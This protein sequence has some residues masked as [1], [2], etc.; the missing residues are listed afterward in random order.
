MFSSKY[1]RGL[2]AVCLILTLA[3]AAS[4]APPAERFLAAMQTLSD[5][6]A[7]GRAAT[8][9][10]AANFTARE[11]QAVDQTGGGFSTAE[12]SAGNVRWGE[13]GNRWDYEELS[14]DP[15]DPDVL[16]GEA[17]DV[18]RELAESRR[19]VPWRSALTRSRRI[20]FR[21]RPL[22]GVVRPAE[23]ADDGPLDVRPSDCWYA[24]VVGG[25]ADP[26]DELFGRFVAE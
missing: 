9:G 6:V 22:I 12:V 11:F 24:L 19:L 15:A 21:G 7:A 1:S 25:D 13:R 14:I 16:F 3:P 17:Y 20:D 8:A 5:A 18:R 4:A 26:L 10:G 23:G 2:P